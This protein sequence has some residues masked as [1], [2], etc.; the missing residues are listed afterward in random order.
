MRLIA[1]ATA[2]AMF[3]SLVVPASAATFGNSGLSQ[4]AKE[5]SS[6]DLVAAKKKAKKKGKK[7]KKGPK[8]YKF[9]IQTLSPMPWTKGTCSAKAAN[10]EAARTICQTQGNNGFAIRNYNKKTCR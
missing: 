8:T 10:M 2:A 1:S 3:I 5:M 4:T 6:V 9:C 7:G